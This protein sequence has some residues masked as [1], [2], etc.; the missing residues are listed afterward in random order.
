MF[1][2]ADWMK[3]KNSEEKRK[4][5][6]EKSVNPP[7]LKESFAH[8]KENQ[9]I[10]KEI[11]EWEGKTVVIGRDIPVNGMP[12]DYNKSWEG[13]LKPIWALPPKLTKKF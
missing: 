9:R 5:E 3:M 10:K 4:Y 1:D 13:C 12:E 6:Y 11:S 7:P 8:I 2:V